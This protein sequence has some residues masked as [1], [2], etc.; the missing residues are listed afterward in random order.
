V[1]VFGHGVEVCTSTTRPTPTEGSLIYETDTSRYY[2]YN[3]SQWLPV[4][5]P[6][7]IKRVFSSIKT[8]R[9][10]I[11]S[12]SP[13]AISGLSIT[14]TPLSTSSRFLILSTINHNAQ[15]VH[16]FGVYRNGVTIHNNPGSNSNEPNMFYTG[17]L[18]FNADTS[19][20]TNSHISVVDTPNTTSSITYQIYGTSGWVNV[21]YAMRIN[22]R[23]A[24]MRSLSTLTILEY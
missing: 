17:Y 15:Y 7:S 23:N 11:A 8:G 18:G 12:L 6:D 5:Y 21:V 4:T 13:V 14:L 3:G 19:Y 10:D 2:F 16:S 9:Q 24:D 22:D 20:M 1:S